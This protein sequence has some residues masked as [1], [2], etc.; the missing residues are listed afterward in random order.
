MKFLFFSLSLYYMDVK[1]MFPCF[2]KTEFETGD[3][4]L[5]HCYDTENR[6]L[7]GLF[8]YYFSIIV[9]LSSLI[10]L[11]RLSK[12]AMM[13]FSPPLLKNLKQAF[14]FGPILPS[15]KCPAS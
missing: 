11:I 12:D 9:P 1:L 15:K 3:G 4:S 10:A 2:S 13:A 14:T 6:P 8:G 7:F 5:Y